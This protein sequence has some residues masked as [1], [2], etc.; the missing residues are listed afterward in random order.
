MK[1]LVTAASL[2]IV[3]VAATGAVTRLPSADGQFW[4][5]QDTSPWAQDSGGIAT[6]GRANPF[7][8]FGYLKLEVR[9]IGGTTLTRNLYARG[10]GLAHDGAERFDS[11]TPVFTSGIVIDRGIYA[12][13]DTNYLRYVDTFTN[14]SGPAARDQRGVGRRGGRVRGRRSRGR[15]DDVGRQPDH[16]PRRQLRHGDAERARRHRS[17]TRAVGARTVGARARHAHRGSADANRGHVRGPVHR[18]VARL[19]SGARRIRVHLHAPA[20]RG[21]LA[22][23][24]RR[25]GS[26]RGIRP[27]RRFSD[28]DHRRNRCTEERR[29]VLRRRAGGPGGRHADRGR[30]RDRATAGR[31]PRRTRPHAAPAG[32]GF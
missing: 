10:F 29:A 30:H 21:R 18:R 27:P 32:R 15:R 2:V 12:P 11:I 6:G 26:Q 31:G 19:R 5:I 13:K 16:R 7:N 17:G 24:V 25:Q 1:R 8:G 28:S 9:T 3:A 23:D 14:T 20:R 4:D 22:D